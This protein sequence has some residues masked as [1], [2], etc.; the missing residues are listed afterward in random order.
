MPTTKSDEMRAALEDGMNQEVMQPATEID[1]LIGL[2]VRAA[3]SGEKDVLS[4]VAGMQ[5]GVKLAGILLND[6]H[7]MADAQEIIAKY[8]LTLEPGRETL[9]GQRKG[10]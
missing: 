2:C 9:F 6:L 8:V 10:Q 5:A 1:T 4:T 7:R 3:L